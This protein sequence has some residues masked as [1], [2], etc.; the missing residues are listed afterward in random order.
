MEAWKTIWDL[1]QKMKIQVKHVD[2]HKTDSS[3]ETKFKNKVGKLA[4]LAVK[5]KAQYESEPLGPSRIKI[6]RGWKIY[7]SQEPKKVMPPTQEEILK[8]HSHLGHVGTHALKSWFDQR[9]IKISWKLLQN[10]IRQCPNCPATGT[11]FRHNYHGPVGHKLSFNHTVQI[12]WIGP[13]ANYNNKYACTMVDITTGLSL[14]MPHN[15]PDHRGTI[16]TLWKWISAYNTPLV[17][18]SDQGTHFTSKNTQNFPKTLDIFWEFHQPYTP[19]AAGA[20]ERF[21][22]LLKTKLSENKENDLSW[23]LYKSTYELNI[24]PRLNRCSPF[25]EALNTEPP[26]DP[27]TSKNRNFIKSYMTIYRNPKDKS[28]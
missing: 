15:K 1:G 24:R 6:S 28:L 23:A 19:T 16:M 27:P 21:N 26:C 18:Q 11:R 3:E 8:L 5:L 22:G 4:A 17:I 13:L 2:A 25:R 14:A 12:G 7:P 9:N 10:T 20:I